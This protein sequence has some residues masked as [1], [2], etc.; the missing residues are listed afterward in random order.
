MNS[1]IWALVA[2]C[3]GMLLGELGGRLVRAA[4]GGADREPHVRSTAK[5]VGSLVFWSF[6]AVG[7]V[8]AV[9]VLDS[10]AL[11]DIGATLSDSLPDL[12]LAFVMVIVGYA[13]A[14][15]VST[16]IG[17]SARRASGVRQQNLE[18][19][20][21][22]LITT[23]AGLLGLHLA[24]V[25]APTIGALVVI[26]LVVP[27]LSVALLTSFG[28]RD[29]ASQLAAGRALRAQLR[30]GW[31]LTCRDER[32]DTVSGRIVRVHP[33]TVEIE[34]DSGGVCH[35]PNS[36]LLNRPFTVDR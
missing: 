17:Q 27:A 5:A 29:V 18:R 14:I 31:V 12:L 36:C 32:G 10:D 9:G 1:W 23:I 26:A 3:S 21:R 30:E 19:A 22:I 2:V 34:A 16:A 4:R 8:V 28:G 20:L 13:V 7:L 35:V 11:T 15:A 6:T 33:A 25:D 24:R